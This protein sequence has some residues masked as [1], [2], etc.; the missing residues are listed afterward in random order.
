MKKKLIK[1][2]MEYMLSIYP[3]I[4]KG[5]DKDFKEFDEKW[6]LHTKHSTHL[7]DYE[8]PFV[9]DEVKSYIL[10]RDKALIEGIHSHLVSVEARIAKEGL[11]SDYENGYFEAIDD[12]AKWINTYL[13]TLQ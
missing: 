3:L 12:M 2:D 9:G 4:E 6:N 5:Y 7:G 1:K 8:Y 10:S 11:N 13:D